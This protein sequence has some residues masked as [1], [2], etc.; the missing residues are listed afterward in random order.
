MGVAEVVSALDRAGP[1]RVRTARLAGCRRPGAPRSCATSQPTPRPSA[2]WPGL[3][4]GW[5]TIRQ[6]RSCSAA[7]T[8]R[9]WRPRIYFLLGSG[10]VQQ[11][12]AEPAIVVLEKA[13]TLDPSHAETL[14]ELAR[15][16]ARLKRLGDA[17]EVAEQ[18]AALPGWEAKRRRDSRRT[19][20]R[21]GLIPPV[22]ERRSPVPCRPTRTCAAR[23]LLLRRFASCLLAPCSRPVSRHWQ[24]LTSRPY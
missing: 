6:P 2:S 3:T 10:L 18:L 12:R 19:C 14:H 5:G 7:S 22:L 24:R 13:R 17:V 11:D 9:R 16:Y 1:R 4:A 23:W 21:S 8:T 20:A 15:L